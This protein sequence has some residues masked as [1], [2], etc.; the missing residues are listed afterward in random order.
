MCKLE[1][2]QSFVFHFSLSLSVAYFF[3]SFAHPP[4][5][6]CKPWNKDGPNPCAHRPDT[7]YCSLEGDFCVQLTSGTPSVHTTHDHMSLDLRNS[8]YFYLLIITDT[9]FTLGLKEQRP[10]PDSHL[11]SILKICSCN[12]DLC[13]I[14]H[15]RNHHR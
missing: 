7:R 9:V 14:S 13:V 10:F 2:G 12:V 8:V 1:K 6:S 15:F 11:E 4:L 5:A 3:I